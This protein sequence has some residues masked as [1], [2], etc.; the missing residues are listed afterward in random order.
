VTPWTAFGWL[1]EGVFVSRLA[2]QWAL[3]EYRGESVV[4]PVFWWLGL[5][6]SLMLTIYA[7]GRRDYPIASGQLLT[8]FIFSRNLMLLRKAAVITG[9][10]A[11]AGACRA[12][13]QSPEAKP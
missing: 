3:S 4:P 5:G 8:V 12:R 6:G 2:V 1:A 10:R 9:K 7:L 13:R 11:T